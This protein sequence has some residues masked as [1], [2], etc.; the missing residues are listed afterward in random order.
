MSDEVAYIGNHFKWQ[1]K[2]HPHDPITVLVLHPWPKSDL[3]TPVW[4]RWDWGCRM[5]D[6]QELTVFTREL[7]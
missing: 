4:A 2:D 1:S 3:Y 6:G 7:T 5:D